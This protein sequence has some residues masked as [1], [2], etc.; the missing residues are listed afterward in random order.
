MVWFVT[1]VDSP[2]EPQ[3]APTNTTTENSSMT[4]IMLFEH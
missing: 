2:T 3:L 1:A 4:T